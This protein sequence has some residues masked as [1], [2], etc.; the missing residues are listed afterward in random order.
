MGIL[1]EINEVLKG[2]KSDVSELS[3]KVFD[4]ELNNNKNS[5]DDAIIFRFNKGDKLNLT[6]ASKFLGLHHSEIK[7][8]VYNGELPS[9]TKTHYTFYAEDLIS[10]KNQLKNKKSPLIKTHSTRKIKKQSP[11]VSQDELAELAELNS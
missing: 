10:Y 5:N 2:L 8:L 7:E 9:A 4:M 3:Q 11:I 1:E 6:F